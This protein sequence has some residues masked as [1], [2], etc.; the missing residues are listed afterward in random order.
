METMQKRERESQN[1]SNFDG[2]CYIRY[3]DEEYEWNKWAEKLFNSTAL[4][5]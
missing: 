4:G 2:V 5:A 3:D 1:V